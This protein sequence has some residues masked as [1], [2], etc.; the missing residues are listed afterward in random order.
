VDKYQDRYT[1]HQKRK[2][3][4]LK[5]I[6]DTHYSTRQF[7]DKVVEQE[8][9]DILVNSI[10]LIPSSCDRH[11]V[12]AKVIS[13]RDNKNLL[14]GLLVGGTGWV[15][16]ASHIIL[17]FGDPEAYKEGLIYM[18]YLDAGVAVMKLYDTAKEL[19]LKGCYVNPQV[20]GD[21]QIYFRD[22]FGHDIYCGAFGVG[23]EA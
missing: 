7:S 14:S 4:T 16:R 13:D 21:N 20:R 2:R 19:V 17:L 15:H 1:A 22:R 5:K 9:I 8:K 11:G 10:Q 6:G 23:Y 3:D 18:S 12:Y